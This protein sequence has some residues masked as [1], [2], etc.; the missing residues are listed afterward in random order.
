MSASEVIKGDSGFTLV[1]QTKR[2]S[3]ETGWSVVKLYEGP[4]ATHET[5]A[6]TLIAAGATSLDVGTGVPCQITATFPASYGTWISDQKAQDE[7]VW[8]L[9]GEPVEKRIETHGK[10]L[11]STSSAA[12]LEKIDAAIRAGTA[13]STNWEAAP[14]TGLGAFNSYLQL[15]LMG[16]ESYES[17]IYRVRSTQTVSKESLLTAS[18][19]NVGKVI[20]WSAIGV[21]AKAKFAQP[22]IHMCKPL[23][24]SIVGYTDEPV[25]EWLT[26]PPSVRWRKGLRKWEIV[27]EW[28]GAVAISSTLYDGGTATP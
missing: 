9:I 11:A 12:V 19:A 20:A 13:S 14:Y 8:E 10:F 27:N 15:R 4:Q 26:Q 18:F 3:P 28:I 5:Y 16:T 6:D 25:N 2:W 7:A 21:P 23:T 24:G 1:K 17:Y 22:V